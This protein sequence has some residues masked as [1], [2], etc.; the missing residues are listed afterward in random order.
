MA[1]DMSKNFHASRP[2]VPLRFMRR[3]WLSSTAIYLVPA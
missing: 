1:H 3:F 2:S